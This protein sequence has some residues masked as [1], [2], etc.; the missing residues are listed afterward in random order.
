MVHVICRWV[1]GLEPPALFPCEMHTPSYDMGLVLTRNAFFFGRTPQVDKSAAAQ[2]DSTMSLLKPKS[3]PFGKR[4]ASRTWQGQILCT[5][6]DTRTIILCTCRHQAT[7]LARAGLECI[8][9]Q[10]EV[11]WESLVKQPAKHSPYA[12]G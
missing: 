11:A 9:T 12:T 3:M 8:H 10:Y 6:L 7:W 5:L 1:L 2:A 4:K